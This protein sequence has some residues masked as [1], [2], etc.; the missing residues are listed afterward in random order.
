MAL[1]GKC[2]CGAEALRGYD[3]CPAHLRDWETFT[4]DNTTAPRFMPIYKTS[5]EDAVDGNAVTAY[6]MCEKGYE[7]AARYTAPSGELR[8]C[9]VLPD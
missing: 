9:L 8:F 4:I 3:H 6:E 5:Y 1:K 2:T 7:V